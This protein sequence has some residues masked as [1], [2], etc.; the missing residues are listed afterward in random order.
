MK[1]PK[2]SLFRATLTSFRYAPASGAS[3]ERAGTQVFVI[4]SA[5]ACMS[6]RFASSGQGLVAYSTCQKYKIKAHQENED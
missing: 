1:L 6:L 5:L 2:K 4:V 3:L